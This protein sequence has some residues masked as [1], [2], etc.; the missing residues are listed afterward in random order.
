LHDDGTL[1]IDYGCGPSFPCMVNGTVNA[2]SPLPPPATCTS[3]ARAG[4]A[5]ASD[6]AWLVSIFI[7]GSSRQDSDF[8]IRISPQ[9]CN[10][11][12]MEGSTRGT[13]RTAS[14]TPPGRDRVQQ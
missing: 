13:T 8:T 14:F 3:C 2:Q 11:A 6:V 4:P 10:P 1:S 9:T 7:L 12:V 5:A